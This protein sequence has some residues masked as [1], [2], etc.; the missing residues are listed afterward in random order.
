MRPESKHRRHQLVARS[1]P[2]LVEAEEPERAEEERGGAGPEE[3]VAVR[4][5]ELGHAGVA[6]GRHKV[7]PVVCVGRR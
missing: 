2:A 6:V 3:G 4:P 7:H 5:H 1:D